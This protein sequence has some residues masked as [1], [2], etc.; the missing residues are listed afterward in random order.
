VREKTWRERVEEEGS[1][2]SETLRLCARDKRN[3]QGGK[4]IK[5]KGAIE[6]TFLKK[7]QLVTC[8]ISHVRIW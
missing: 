5:R 4:K 7:F 6:F 8:E 3:N 2:S 1:D